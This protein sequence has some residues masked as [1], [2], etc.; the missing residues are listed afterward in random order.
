MSDTLP[1]AANVSPTLASELIAALVDGDKDAIAQRMAGLL[2]PSWFGTGAT[3]VDGKTG[4]AGAPILNVILS[5]GAYN[6]SWIYVL[7]EYVLKQSRIATAT[8]VWLDRI[9]YD[10][11]GNKLLRRNGER[12]N[13]YRLRI[14]Q[15][16][17]R[18]R[19]TRQ[20][21][22]DAL[23]DLTGNTPQ[24]ME[25][26]NP[27]DCGGYGEPVA[28]GYGV[29]GAY[30]SLAR[31]NQVFITAFRPAGGGIAS[32]AAY[33]VPASGY[34]VGTCE[35]IDDS[36]VQVN[37]SDDE[38]YS[39]VANVVAAGITG[40]VAILS[41]TNPTGASQLYFGSVADSQAL[42]MIPGF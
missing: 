24:I 2:P 40:W 12:D 38:I 37:A 11:F 21:I 34:G 36:W 42:A 31:R 14:Y 1:N 39:T 20:A 15:E 28:C 33:G 35:Y 10:F 17:F 4:E 18:Q 25:M 13:Q 9:A 5:G 41:K 19:Q 16:L 29:A 26:W 32:V 27:G 22:T 23:I 7:Y 30:G 8:G 6:L 3:Q